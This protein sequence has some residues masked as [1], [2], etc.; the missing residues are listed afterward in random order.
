MMF[1][2]VGLWERG[3]N[4]LKW[5]NGMEKESSTDWLQY[6]AVKD[7]REM[8]LWRGDN[9]CRIR[10]F[11]HDGAS[12]ISRKYLIIELLKEWQGKW[13]AVRKSSESRSEA[14]T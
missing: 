11:Y 8:M 1:Y 13:H 2:T 10:K 14:T 9:D 7:A 4:V 6:S 3:K 5:W 12:K